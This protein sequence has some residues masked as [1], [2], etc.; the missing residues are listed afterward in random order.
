MDT[1][2]MLIDEVM[3]EDRAPGGSLVGDIAQELTRLLVC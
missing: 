2:S 1:R 3:A